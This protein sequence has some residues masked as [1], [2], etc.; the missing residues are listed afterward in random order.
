MCLLGILSYRAGISETF[1]FT[2]FLL[3]LTTHCTPLALFI[4]EVTMLL[5]RSQKETLDRFFL[6]IKLKNKYNVSS[7]DQ[8]AKI[9]QILAFL[10]LLHA[11]IRKYSKKRRLVF[12][13]S[14]AGNCYVSFLVYYFYTHIEKRKISIHCVDINEKL[15]HNA[16]ATAERLN[17]KNI[18]FHHKDILYYGSDDTVDMVYSL[19]ACDTATDK[20]LY[21]GIKE[22]AKCILSVSCCQHTIKKHLR[23]QR[24]RG[25]TKHRVFKDKMVYMVADALR[26][27]LLEMNAYKTDIIEFISSRYTDK[28]I[29]IRARKSN[30][31]NMTNSRLEYEHISKEFKVAPMLEAY[32]DETPQEN[33][34]EKASPAI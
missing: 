5:N 17:F 7:K 25:I 29:M 20:T 22:K 13:D 24:Y 21:L 33:L 11:E 4:Q 12:I 2:K 9:E 15:M 18:Y 34:R 16:R 8:E 23:N 30:A 19:H 31:G 6:E 1:R 14:A 28:N 32:L 26:A 10:E 27:L 3:Y